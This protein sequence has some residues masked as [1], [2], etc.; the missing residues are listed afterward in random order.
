MFCRKGKKA[1]AFCI[2][3]RNILCKT[4]KSFL[5]SSRAFFR[6]LFYLLAGS[7]SDR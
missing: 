2:K 3:E 5:K 6:S 4:P 7:V 1:S